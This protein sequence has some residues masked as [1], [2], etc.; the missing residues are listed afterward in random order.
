MAELSNL[1]ELSAH[2]VPPNLENSG[3]DGLSGQGTQSQDSWQFEPAG[4]AF[5]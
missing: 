3:S 1:K 4:D 5:L 2:G